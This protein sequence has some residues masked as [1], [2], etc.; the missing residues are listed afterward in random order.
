LQLLEVHQGAT[1]KEFSDAARVVYKDDS[2]WVC[3]LDNDIDAIFDAKQNVFY[4]NGEAAR[5]V[6]KSDDGKLIGRVAAFIN[7]SKAFHYAQPTGGMG[8]FECVDDEAA[9]FAL[10]EQSRLWL[11]QRGIHAMDGPINFGEND[12]YWGLLVEGFVAPGY[13]MTYNPPYY[14]K[15]FEDYGFKV[16]YEQVSNHLDLT[17]PFPERFWKIADWI[18]KKPGY[19]FEHLDVKQL[20][21]YVDDF[22]YVYN[23]AWA[24]H[25]NFTPMNRTDLL[26]S[27]TKAKP[28]LDERLIWF[29]YVDNE[30]SAFLILVPDVNQIL[31]HLNGKTSLLAKLKFLYYKRKKTITRGRIVIMGVIPKYQKAGIESGIF[32]HLDEVIKPLN[33]YKELEL[34][35]VGDFNPKMRALHESVG[36]VF[37]KRHY[38]YRKLFDD[39]LEFKRSYVIPVDTKHKRS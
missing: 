16:Y 15:F 2:N 35:W 24:F 8:F 39:G 38:T 34:S 5:W 11:Q 3:P 17:K 28:I 26:R 23:S 9:A 10:F 4:E 18:S 22:L 14:K 21:K 19:R 32:K 29:A 7:R 27:F 13:G 12:R 31:I 37:G 1:A 36:A 30:P 20:D 33:Q 25:E 6:L